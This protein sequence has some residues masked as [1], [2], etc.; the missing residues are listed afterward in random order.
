MEYMEY[1]KRVNRVRRALKPMGYRLGEGEDGPG[2]E[3][4][5]RLNSM[6]KL[7]HDGPLEIDAIEQWIRNF[8]W[9]LH[10]E[11]KAGEA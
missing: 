1:D 4:I 8:D 5:N 10:L 2:Y 6:V 3:V 7:R 9:K 11:A